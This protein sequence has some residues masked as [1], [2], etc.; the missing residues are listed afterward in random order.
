MAWWLSATVLFGVFTLLFAAGVPAAFAFRFDRLMR[1][2]PS[3]RS[4]AT[5]VG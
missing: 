1:A 3:R 5:S 4:E 2:P